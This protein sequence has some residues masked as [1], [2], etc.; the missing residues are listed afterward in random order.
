MPDSPSEKTKLKESSKTNGAENVNTSPKNKNRSDTTTTAT[1][2]PRPPKMGRKRPS[3]FRIKAGCVVAMRTNPEGNCLSKVNADGQSV[4]IF[5]DDSLIPVWTS[6]IKDRDEGLA[7]VGKRVR[8]FLP[9]HLIEGKKR[10]VLEG[11]VTG[12]YEYMTRPDN[13]P[14]KVDLLVDKSM[15]SEFPFLVRTDEDSS[16]LPTEKA[17]RNARLEETI[18][19][20]N[21]CT[22]RVRLSQPGTV[23]GK[24]SLKWV[25]QKIVPKKLLQSTSSSGANGASRVKAETGKRKPDDSDGMDNSGRGTNGNAVDSVA[26]GETVKKKRKIDQN[27]VKYVGD[28][29]DPPDQQVANWRWMASR[30]HETLINTEDLRLRAPEAHIFSVGFVGEVVKVESMPKSS[31]SLAT[32]TVRRMILPE[33]TAAYSSLTFDRAD[34]FDDM[35]NLQNIF[36]APIEELVV[37]SRKIVRQQ[38]PHVVPSGS[39]EDET[40]IC[41]PEFRCCW[42][43]SY[44]RDMFSSIQSIDD[45]NPDEH[46]PVTP[47]CHRCR[48]AVPDTE[49][50]VECC[51]GSCSLAED[52]NAVFFCND[53]IRRL[54]VLCSC[55]LDESTQQ[56]PLC[57]MEFC[58]CR[59]CR[60]RDLNESF[61]AMSGYSGK[62]LKDVSPENV[63]RSAIQSATNHDSVDF[64]LHESILNWTGIP[65]PSSKL[66]TRSKNTVQRA[67]Q[68]GATGRKKTEKSSGKSDRESATETEVKVKEEDSNKFKKTCARLL[69]YDTIRSSQ[70]GSFQDDQVEKKAERPRNLREHWAAVAAVGIDGDDKTSQR[71]E[72]A[73][74][75]RLLKGMAAFSNLDMDTLAS[76][77]PQLRFDR[78][79]IHAWGVFADKDISSG[80]MIVEYRGEIIENAMAEKRERLYEVE[81]IGSDYMFRIDEKFV[82]DATKVGNVARFINAS[83][84]PN[85]YTKIITVDGQKRIVIYAKR[86]VAAGEELCYDYKFPLEYDPAKRIPCRC[87]ASG[88][89]GFM[90]WD[91]KYVV[92][93]DSEAIVADETMQKSNVDKKSQIPSKLMP[94]SVKTTAPAQDDRRKQCSNE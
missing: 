59:S 35:D 22:V 39:G 34:L 19:G 79:S 32:V 63:F 45:D 48:R 43:Y 21:K 55:S 88:C 41:L 44:G 64:G 38:S 47:T 56:S 30:Y 27:V 72:R 13:K 89:R 92:L 5:P 29:D 85:C 16:Q 57:Y 4:S 78:S 18:R 77:E 68:K 23:D 90:N 49:T 82:C 69:A 26:E 67:L 46:Q 86:D 53:C 75:R 84:D 52:G 31:R 83:C 73:K 37:L 2:A 25:I 71:A 17:R 8:C 20:V 87:G 42:G 14:W 80:D 51:S 24:N 50:S 76:R 36:R 6:P 11:E 40:V 60:V 91:K 62:K 93:G 28:R 61:T 74:Q 10:R 70:K 7:L 58:E 12:V 1:P 15:L 54:G 94:G 81:N 66:I 33:H 65:T 9:K 3:P